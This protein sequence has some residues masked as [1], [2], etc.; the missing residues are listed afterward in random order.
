MAGW[1][2]GVV[3]EAAVATGGGGWSDAVSA[4]C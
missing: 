2:G 1:G 3:G 4:G